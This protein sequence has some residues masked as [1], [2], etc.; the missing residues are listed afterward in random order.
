VEERMS[1][2]EEFGEQGRL[3]EEGVDSYSS[4]DEKQEQETVKDM[5]REL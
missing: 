4:E 3:Y 5:L 2:K 1:S